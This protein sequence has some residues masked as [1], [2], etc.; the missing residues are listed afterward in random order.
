MILRMV[1]VR[2]ALGAGTLLVVSVII[3]LCMALLPGDFATEVLGQNATP[4]AV[5]V[6]R[7]QIGLNKNPVTRYIEWVSGAVRGDF[8]NS[9]VGI[10]AANKAPSR[11]VVGLIAPRLFNSLLLALLTA[12]IAVP[13]AVGLGIFAALYRNSLI[14]RVIS[15]TFVAL[16]AIPE[17]FIAYI[18]MLFFVVR[19]PIFP[20]I[21]DIPFNA[22]LGEHLY[23]ALLPAI[24]LTCVVV[25]HIMRMTRASIISLLASPFIEMAR[26]KGLTQREVILRHALPNAWGPIANV[27]ALNL[28]YMM[29]GV[30]V[31]EVVFVYPGVGQLMIDSVSIRDIPV[32]QA[33]ALIFSTVY[34]ALNVLADIITIVSNPRLLHPR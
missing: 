6:F 3:F 21:S 32:V 1:A 30:V 11:S 28:A 33:V 8:G 4:E 25:A 27:I 24:T 19:L 31:V 23:Y 26:L 13:I 20:A 12:I 7:E 14:D 22:S 29:V 10:S 17:F 5:D 9:F 2:I 18:L 34:I 15:S 16:I